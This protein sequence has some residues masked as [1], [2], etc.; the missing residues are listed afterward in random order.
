MVPGRKGPTEVKVDEYPRPGTTIEALAKLKPCFIN[1]STVVYLL[2][3]FQFL[4]CYCKYWLSLLAVDK[5]RAY[6][7]PL[8]DIGHYMSFN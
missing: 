8:S 7:Q 3:A 6:S 2:S 1:V 4:I 5:V